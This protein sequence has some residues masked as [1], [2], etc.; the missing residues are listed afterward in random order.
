LRGAG[1]DQCQ[2][3]IEGQIGILRSDLAAALS[4]LHVLAGLAVTEVEMVRD[5]GELLDVTNPLLGLDQ[6]HRPHAL[7]GSDRVGRGVDRGSVLGLDL[8][9]EIVDTWGI[10][11]GPGAHVD[12]APRGMLHG[13]SLYLVST[14]GRIAH[15]TIEGRPWRRRGLT[16]ANAA[17]WRPCGVPRKRAPDQVRDREIDSG[18]HGIGE[19]ERP[20]RSRG[21]R[22]AIWAD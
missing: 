17:T 2:G 1:G 19:N 9:R 14:C 4:E 10:C 13:R 20:E 6:E 7:E 8:A 5:P 3:A 18:P 11:P 15:G 21:R 12:A 22:S 16:G